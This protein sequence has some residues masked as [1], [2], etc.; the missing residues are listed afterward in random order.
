MLYTERGKALPIFSSTLQRLVENLA[1]GNNLPYA[2][3]WSL[4]FRIVADVRIPQ[5][6][7]LVYHSDF[8][9]F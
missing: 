9:G 2:V 8:G 5:K 6:L 1:H 7:T 3:F 4:A